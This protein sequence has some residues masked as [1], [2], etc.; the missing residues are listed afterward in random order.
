MELMSMKIN[1]IKSL[2]V[3][4]FCFTMI[5]ISKADNNNFINDEQELKA[6]DIAANKIYNKA[7]DLFNKGK[8]WQCSQKLFI[9]MDFYT[10]FSQLDGVIYHMAECLYEEEMNDAS[11]K[12][13]KYIIKNYSGCEY[14]PASLFGLQKAHYKI[15]NYKKA[16]TVYYRILKDKNNA[17]VINAARYFAGQSHFHLKNFDTTI[18]LLKYIDN[19]NQYYDGALYTTALSHLKKKSVESS[20]EYF[21]KLIS[22]PIVSGERRKMVDNGRL[23]LGFIF[24][25]INLYK[26]AIDLFEDISNEHDGYQDALLALGW[27]YLKLGRYEQGK[28]SLLKLIDL[29]P[30][31]ANAEES[32]FLL[33]QAYIMS[34]EYDSSIEAYK[35]I[36]DLYPSSLQNIKII[37]KINN[38]LSQQQNKVEKLKVQVLIQESKLLTSM[39]INTS[40]ENMSNE[41]DQQEKKLRKYREGLI[42]NLIA[43]RESL[44]YMRNQLTQL[45]KTAERKERRKDW[46]GYAEYGISRALF[47]KEMQYKAN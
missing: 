21:K 41:L 4:L 32:Y 43:E 6:L 11:M 30:Q 36:V 45:K 23:T 18:N 37:K 34:G 14:I 31:S 9:I 25:E 12:M 40:S 1:Y 10:E 5:N 38:S 26:D 28:E 33:G 22:L 16:L 29:F 44:L 3:L 39:S 27:C 46:C 42:K 19:K 17:S 8:Y 47:L 7:L 13:Y 24:Y 2:A 35:I 20:I 15:G